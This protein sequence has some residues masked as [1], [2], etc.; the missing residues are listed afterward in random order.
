MTSRK[1]LNN[2][3]MNSDVVIVKAQRLQRPNETI[4]IDFPAYFMY[5][6][7]VSDKKW[8]M[9]KGPTSKF[10]VK[11]IYGHIEKKLEMGTQQENIISWYDY[12]EQACNDPG[13]QIRFYRLATKD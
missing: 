10:Y 7:N 9:I 1:S 4:N 8:I 2:V 13:G 12:L 11:H 6:L 5:K 3:K